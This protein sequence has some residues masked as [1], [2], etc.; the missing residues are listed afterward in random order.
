MKRT[1]LASE[2]NANMKLTV[3]LSHVIL[4]WTFTAQVTGE[5]LWTV[6]NYGTLNGTIE[7]STYTN[8]PFH[9][10]RSVFYAEMP[11][12]EIRFLVCIPQSY[13]R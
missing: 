4:L 6:P 8:R 5:F 1:A 7:S 10:F 12:P 3:L 9:A 13:S 2:V 11:T